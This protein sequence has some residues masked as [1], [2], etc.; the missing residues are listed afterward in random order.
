MNVWEWGEMI[1]LGPTKRHNQSE[2]QPVCATVATCRHPQSLQTSCATHTRP[3]LTSLPLSTGLLGLLRT[4]TGLLGILREVT[5][6]TMAPGRGA[7]VGGTTP[8]P[9]LWL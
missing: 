7:P 5:G 3:Q 9:D 4:L 8:K 2:P 1:V 6:F